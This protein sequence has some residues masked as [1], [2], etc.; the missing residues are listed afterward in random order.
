MPATKYLLNTFSNEAKMKT[1]LHG[2]EP[3]GLDVVTIVQAHPH[4]FV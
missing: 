3:P 2:T 1:Y 4:N